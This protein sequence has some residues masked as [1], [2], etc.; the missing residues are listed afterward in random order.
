[1]AS[2]RA[3]LSGKSEPS[4]T[5][6]PA[7]TETKERVQ[8]PGKAE[9]SKAKAPPSPPMAATPAPAPE[10]V[11]EPVSLTPKPRDP[12]TG[13]HP[14]VRE[15]AVPRRSMPMVFALGVCMF[16][17]GA[18]G[19]F[20]WGYF[21]AEGLPALGPHLLAFAAIITLVPA[22]LFVAAAYALTRA[23]AMGDV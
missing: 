6:A 10:P 7:K 3:E 11:R 9:R 14:I 2:L 15:V 21:G 1:M 8:P 20:L 19:A 18:S 4:E 13:I 5:P 22:F 23:Q 16:W 17:I 12:T